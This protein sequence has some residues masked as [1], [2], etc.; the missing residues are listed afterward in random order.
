MST[1]CQIKIL[2]TSYMAAFLK[3]GAAACTWSS[4]GASSD[5]LETILADVY[6]EGVIR[7]LGS[8]IYSLKYLRDVKN[9]PDEEDITKRISPGA[10]F[11][12]SPWGK[13]P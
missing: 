11:F 6:W 10:A 3:P 13:H 12:V 8:T 2:F 4:D 1:A 5:Q 7:E 9:I